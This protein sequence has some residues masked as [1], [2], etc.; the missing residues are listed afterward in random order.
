MTTT[1]APA[2]SE[3]EMLRDAIAYCEANGADAEHIAR[4][5]AALTK[6][7]GRPEAPTATDAPLPTGGTGTGRA[8]RP[9]RDYTRQ[10]A[11]FETLLS[12]KC[13]PEQAA[14]LRA[15]V[16]D[17][18]VKRSNAIDKLNN[19]AELP[20]DKPDAQLKYLTSLISRK[21]DPA[22]TAQMLI[23]VQAMNRPERSRLIDNLK[24][25]RDVVTPAAST[26]ASAATG[27]VGPGT[28]L[29]DGEVYQ[30]KEGKRYANRLNRETMRFEYA[31]G[32]IHQLTPAHK[33]TLEQAK[34]FGDLTHH[35]ACCGK[36]LTKKL[37]IERGVGPVCYG[38]F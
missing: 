38:N 25:Q 26:P 33:L 22:R 34:Q 37:S 19:M 9:A 16:G 35:C 20:S 29:M 15:E 12:R 18:P 5:H 23:M 21:V 32:A 14:K 13:T 10:I 4:L 36:R 7:L 2:T 27:P 28:Y 30:V 11:W 17:S 24:T 31:K 3:V 1:T 6:R 8:T